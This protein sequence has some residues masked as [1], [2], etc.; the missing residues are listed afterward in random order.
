MA[1]YDGYVRVGIVHE[2]YEDM[3]FIRNI[4]ENRRNLTGLI[5]VVDNEIER[6][7]AY[8]KEEQENRDSM[9]EA[10]NKIKQRLAMSE[11]ELNETNA[12]E[13]PS[14]A[15]TFGQLKFA[16]KTHSVR[17]TDKSLND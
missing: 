4:I 2:D 12:A 13:G 15:A 8:E 5:E 14:E 7:D 11:E 6:I 3:I 17:V 1:Y 9:L 10:M 16:F